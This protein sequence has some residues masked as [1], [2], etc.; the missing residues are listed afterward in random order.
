MPHERRIVVVHG[1]H[2]AEGES[3]VWQL[4]PG[5]EAETG[6]EVGVFEYGFMSFWSARFRN[7]KIAE[8]LAAIVQPGD[9]IV[10]HSNG[11]AVTYLA[12]R[13]FGMRPSVVACVN[14]ALDNDLLFRGAS[15][16]DV[17]YNAGDTWV[18]LASILI[19]HVWG[20]MG[21]VGY[22]GQHPGV[23]NIDCGNTPGMPKVDGHIDLFSAGKADLWSRYIGIR[24][25]N[26]LEGL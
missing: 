24:I 5:L 10:N 6:L 8:R 19:G 7:S 20:D 4:R 15:E 2:A 18:G 13:D 17:Y 22:K 16:T 1:I 14:P 26:H 11:A 23:H 9:V 21:K 3:H 12:C 25:R